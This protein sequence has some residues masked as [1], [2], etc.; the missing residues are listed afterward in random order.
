M[1]TLWPAQWINRYSGHF[2]CSYSQKDANDPSHK[3]GLKKFDVFVFHKPI[4]AFQMLAEFIRS[5][6]PEKVIV[7]D[8]DDYEKEIFDTLYPLWYFNGLPVEPSEAFP[9]ADG[10]TLASVPLMEEYKSVGPCA[11]IEN[12]FDLNLI[13]NRPQHN[14]YWNQTV[15]IAYGGGVTHARDLTEI[16]KLGVLQDLCDLYDVDF[17]IYG[18]LKGAGYEP[19][20]FKKGSI[21]AKP[22]RPIAT[23]ISDLYHDADALFA[24]LIQDRFNGFRSTLKL[25]EAGVI[26]KTIVASRVNTYED[27]IGRDCVHLVDNTYSQWFSALESCILDKARTKKLG[28]KNRRVVEEHYSAEVLTDQRI[29]FYKQ[30]LESK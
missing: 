15:K 2:A 21:Y 30:L 11:V 29:A 20:K 9:L 17:Y 5:R 19:K 24:P 12:G 8:T 16:L 23:Y 25:V 1:R 18:V 26:G 3:Y 4:P 14:Q 22:G 27:Y 28:Q 13:D 7:F 6:W 10:Y